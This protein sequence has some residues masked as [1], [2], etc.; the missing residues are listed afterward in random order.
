VSDT[1]QGPGW[2]QASDGKWYPPEQAPGGGAAP[3]G[4]GAG[5]DTSF[6][7]VFSYAWQKFI[8]NIGEWLV[9]WLILL[10]IAIVLVVLTTVVAVGGAS[11]GI[12]F[13]FNVIGIVLSLIFGAV[14][15]VMLVA[16]AKGANMAVNGQKIDIGACFKFTGNNIVAGALFGLISAV[17]GY[18]CFIFSIV[19]WLF[20][21]FIPVL[22]AV[23]DKGADAIGESVSLS[24]SRAGESL[25]FWAVAWLITGCLCFIG[26]PIAMIGGTY[27]VKRFRGEA[28]AA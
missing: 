27:L 11:T 23:D 14:Q 10:A 28:V 5:G 24:S 9:L 25:P 21:G 2:W 22:S 8:Q 7:T 6:G 20:G 16:V 3:G 18:F 26:S 4:G 1:P 19:V 17:L 12:G 13:R 15:G